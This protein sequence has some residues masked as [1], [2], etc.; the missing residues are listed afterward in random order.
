MV[1]VLVKDARMTMLERQKDA[2]WAESKTTV[3]DN[4]SHLLK[5]ACENGHTHVSQKDFQILGNDYQSN[6]KRK[7]SES[8]FIRQLKPMLNVNEKLITLDL[9]N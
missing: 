1:S 2:F 5:H 8:L 7:I 6:F 9:F 3:K 4:S